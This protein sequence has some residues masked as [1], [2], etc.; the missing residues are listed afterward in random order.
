MPTPV[1]R[2]IV[3]AIVAAL[4]ASQAHAQEV[5]L[6]LATVAPDGTPWAKSLKSYKKAVEDAS[7]GRIKVKVF[8]GGSLGDENETVLACKRGQVQGVAVSVGAMATLVPELNVL[9]IPYLFRSAKEADTTLDSPQILA[10]L[11]K[12][13]NGKGFSLLFWSENGF[14]SFGTKDGFVK[15]PADLKGKKM[16]SQENPVHLAMYR[17]FGGSPVPIAVTEVLTSLQTGVVDGFDNTPLYAF[18]AS[19]HTAIKYFTVTEHIY[20]PAV[21]AVKKDWLD[22]LQPDVRKILLDARGDIPKKLRA[23]LRAMTP[24]LLKNLE[25]AGIQ[26]YRLSASEIASF[27]PAAQKARDEFLKGSG[28]STKAFYETVATALKAAR[29]K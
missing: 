17:A 18:A 11:E 10:E 14:R 27:A 3:L 26:V 12:I 23:Q 19:W 25:S 13:L 6:K 24:I 29:G 7:Q 22:A 1:A 8:L 16:R 21:I 2:T 20:Q 28:A 15:S 9:E 4:L 5:V